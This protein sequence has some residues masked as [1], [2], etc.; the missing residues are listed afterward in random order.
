MIFFWDSLF[1]DGA[2]WTFEPSDS[3]V[4]ASEYF[5]NNNITN[6]LIPGVGYG[7]N[8]SPFIKKRMTITGIEIS[9]KAIETARLNNI[10]FPI[11]HGTVLDM[12][13]SN[14]NYDGI[15]CYSLLHLLNRIERKKFLQKCY[16]QLSPGGK[17]IFVVISTKSEM[18]GDGIMLS[19][20]RFKVRNG[21]GV[22]FYTPLAIVKE[23]T[24][25][26]LLEYKEFDEPIKHI[27]YSPD[28]KC[29]Y[30]LCKKD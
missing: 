26:G 3:S 5:Y 28:L 15:Y 20:N 23:F 30:I 18:Y 16:N 4:I 11:Y 21:L 17:M 7:R 29:Y 2:I 8:C 27:K 9:S 19:A 13:F 10:T 1:E 6:I 22:Y 12:P 14:Q 24:A 25:F